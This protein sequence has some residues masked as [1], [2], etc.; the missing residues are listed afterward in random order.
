MSINWDPTRTFQ[1]AASWSRNLRLLE[2]FSSTPPQ[3][4]SY[5]DRM[6]KF[7]IVVAIVVAVS[8]VCTA[9]PNQRDIL[10]KL[11]DIDGYDKLYN[12]QVSYAGQEPKDALMKYVEA[13][14][15]DLRMDYG[16]LRKQVFETPCNEVTK[17]YE[18][19]KAYFDGL[20]SGGSSFDTNFPAKVKS[21]VS[22]CKVYLEGNNL[23][24]V[25]DEVFNPPKN[26][27]E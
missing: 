21:V 17:L 20:S 10:K 18:A 26:A 4:Q 13:N 27:K 5:A 9:N 24:T 16:K 12:I 25:Y 6:I 22:A 2:Q 7:A 8:E 3:V 11:M 14:K 19:N 15:D 1:C 23:K